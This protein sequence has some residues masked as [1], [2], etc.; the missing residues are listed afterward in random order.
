MDEFQRVSSSQLG[1][2][3]FKL[4][5]VNIL[6]VVNDGHFIWLSSSRIEITL[7]HSCYV[8]NLS[9][10]VWN[11]L[12]ELI[13]VIN[14]GG[15]LNISFKLIYLRIF[16]YLYFEI[17]VSNLEFNNFIN[18]SNTKNSVL[19]FGEWTR[20]GCLTVLPDLSKKSLYDPVLIN[21]TC[22]QLSTF[23]VLV[24]E[25]H[26][27]VSIFFLLIHIQIEIEL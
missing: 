14:R 4:K 19:R 20:A 17:L 10:R 15:F 8:I 22:N 23:A 7:Y 2:M 6:I 1:T 3:K 18:C 11:I 25:I 21:C 12:F 24:D 5:T 13:S 27:Q 16:L 26:G 9:I